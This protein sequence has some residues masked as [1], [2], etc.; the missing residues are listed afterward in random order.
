VISPELGQCKRNCWDYL[1]KYTEAF[2]FRDVNESELRVDLWRAEKDRIRIQLFGADNPNALAGYYMD[3]CNLDEAQDHAPDFFG[4]IIRPLLSDR[5][6]WAH[7]YGTA[8]GKNY[9][10]Q[11]RRRYREKMLAGDPNYFEIEL[12]ASQTNI[13][14]K[15]E[16]QMAREEMGEDMYL[17]EFELN[18]EAPVKGSYYGELLNRAEQDGRICNVPYDP[19]LEVEV[20]F[21]LGIDD[22]MSLWFVQR[23]GQEIRVI[24]YDE[25]SGLGIPEWCGRMR[26]K[27]YSYG[28]LILP[29]DA[30]ARELGTGKT[31]EEV[32]RKQ[33]F[34]RT[35]IVPRQDVADGIQAVRLILPRRY[36]DKTKTEKGLEAL[37]N[38][39]REYDA[40]T[41]TFK[42]V[43]KHDWSSHAADA[44]RTG[45][46]GSREKP[47]QDPRDYPDCHL[48]FDE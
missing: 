43:P 39:Q 19:S 37:R 13:I 44:F 42:S 16:L 48:G 36:F 23:M 28:S 17:Q 31:R 45:A 9:F 11:L 18:C 21:D 46:M 40:T 26:Q 35:R 15:A 5:G 10:W 30:A 34:H 32:F 33:N 14:P 12:K 7:W 8:R 27:P 22:T 1:K 41:K 38:Y 47:S 29:H 6:G 20:W 25:D 2:P 3:G 24:D 4:P